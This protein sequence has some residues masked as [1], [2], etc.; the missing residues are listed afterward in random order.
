[1]KK[2]CQRTEVLQIVAEGH[3]WMPESTSGRKSAQRNAE[4]HEGVQMS[5]RMYK[6]VQ[7]FTITE[8]EVCNSAQK[9]TKVYR[10][11]RYSVQK[12][13]EVHNSV[14]KRT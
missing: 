9:S 2:M 3:K 6:S 5:T 4:E 8:S 11:V 13:A 14:Q 1:M 7:K 10:N 12:C